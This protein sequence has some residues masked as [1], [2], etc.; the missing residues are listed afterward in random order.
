MNILIVCGGTGG[1]LF[2]GMAVGEELILRHHQVALV[3]SEK[4]IDRKAVERARGMLIQTLPAVGWNGVMRAIPFGVGMVRAICRSKQIFRSFV[5]DVVVGMGGFSSVA[6]LLLAWKRKI[7]GL[8]HESNAVAGKANR[9]AAR[10]VQ[11]AAVGFDAAR[12]QFPEGKGV[13]TGTP[14]REILRTP[15]DRPLARSELGLHPD[16][17]TVLVMGGSQGAHGLNRLVADA[18]IA[19]KAAGIQWVH[20][21]GTRDESSLRERYAREG[22]SAQVHAFHHEMHK[23][24]AAADL[25]IA[26]SGAAS[27]AEIAQCALPSILIPY[28]FATDRHQSANARLFAEAG[29]GLVHEE[30]EVTAN[31][32]SGEIQDILTNKSRQKGM[33]EATK[34]LRQ[35]DA[36][37]KLADI[38]EKL[39][40]RH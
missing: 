35:E 11:V 14:V 30:S 28:P 13:W 33:S 16:Q 4:E 26:R 9:M 6:P 12:A 19:S 32:L 22:I 20:L 29:A 38:I 40:K 15:M 23:L 21:S 5:P 39:G 1:H 34:Q 24:Y 10:L 37:K 2:P 17:P 31:Q 8:I 25:I 7:P 3:V 36:H 18:A 27:L